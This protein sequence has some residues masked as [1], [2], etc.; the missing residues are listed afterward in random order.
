MGIQRRVALIGSGRGPWI[1]TLGLLKPVAKVTGLQNGGQIV[2]EMCDGAN[3]EVAEVTFMEA[4]REN[5]KTVLREVHWMRAVG[6][7]AGRNVICDI[8]SMK[9]A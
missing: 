6:Q 2:I 3:P 4:I 7:E 5:G 1:S 8:L 9:V